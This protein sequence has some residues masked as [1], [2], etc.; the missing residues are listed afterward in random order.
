M[1]TGTSHFRTAVE[2]GLEIIKAIQGHTSGMAVPHY[3]IDAPQGG[4]KIPV[5]PDFIQEITE[6]EIVLKNYEGKVYRYPIDS[7]VP[8]AQEVKLS[9]LQT[10]GK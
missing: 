3:V 6:S 2:K 1:V 4:G 10:N 8:N 7:E 5:T 9:Q